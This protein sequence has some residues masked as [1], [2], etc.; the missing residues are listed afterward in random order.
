MQ[1][2]FDGTYLE[3]EDDVWIVT[4]DVTI[5]ELENTD[6]GRCK[7]PSHNVYPF[8]RNTAAHFNSSKFRERR[9]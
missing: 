1:D 7:L 5:K 2:D 4:D 8:Q 3:N 6:I 9:I